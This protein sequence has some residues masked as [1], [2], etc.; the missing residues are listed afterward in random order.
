MTAT[1]LL[2]ISLGTLPTERPAGLFTAQESAEIVQF[3]NQPGR[4]VYEDRTPGQPFHAIATAAGSEWLHD[5]YRRRDPGVPL[6]PG[7][8]PAP[9]TE[10]HQQW[11]RW[12][13]EQRARDKAFAEICATWQSQ[14]LAGLPDLAA[15][16]PIP[17]DLKALAGSPPVFYRPGR[18]Q[19]ATIDLGQKLTFEL[20]VRVPDQFPF[21]RNDLGV[22]SRG[23][24][25]SVPLENVGPDLRKPILAISRLEGGAAAINTYDT[26]GISFGLFQFASLEDGRGSLSVLLQRFRALD[27]TGFKTRLHDRG[28]DVDPSGRLSVVD[29]ENGLEYSGADA[30]RVFR[31]DVRLAAALQMAA[32]EHP[33]LVAAQLDIVQTRYNPLLAKVAFPFSGRTVNIPLA[34]V[35]RSEAGI[36]TLLD[37]LVNR[38]N[39]ASVREVLA[40]K[41]S[42]LGTADLVALA[43]EEADLCRQ[44]AYRADFLADKSLSQPASRPSPLAGNVASARPTIGGSLGPSSSPQPDENSSVAPFDP[45]HLG[46]I[47]QSRPTPDALQPEPGERIGTPPTPRKPSGPITIPGG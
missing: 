8:L 34:K 37:R 20:G 7:N 3:W 29:P 10:R 47:P 25:L 36:A 1:L 21:L 14:G 28:I 30:V 31:R 5:Y 24:E 46:K 12:I 45:S 19:R 44:L 16:N 17:P 4:I 18:W 40:R 43:A 27:P 15:P 2:A 9:R 26:G 6:V 22:A 33:A 41:A 35:F 11:D 38:G 13:A 32:I 39:L 42:E 23:P